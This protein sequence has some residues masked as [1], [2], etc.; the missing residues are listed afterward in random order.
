MGGRPS[1]EDIRKLPVEKAIQE[2]GAHPDTGLAPDEVKKRLTEYGY[3]EV[4]EKKKSPLMSFLK[5]F[6]GLTAWMLELTILISYVLGRLLDLA[7]IAALLLINAILGFFQEQQAERAVEALKKKLSVKAR[8]LRGG[9]WSVLPARELVPGDIVR[10]RSGDFVPAD[11][12]IID[13]DMEVDQSALTGESLPVEKKSGDLLYSGSLVRKGEA[14]G[15]IVSTGTRTYFGRTAQL[16]QAARPKLYVEEVITNLLKWLLAMVIALLA[17]AFIVSYFRGVSLLGLLPLALVLLVSSI[18][19]ALP[20]MFTVT[21]ALGSLELAKRGVL[22]TRLSA[23]Q[24]AAMM[25][26]LCADKT[27]TITM[28]KLSV[29]EMEGVGGYSADDV[30]FYGTLASQEAN[31]DP[32][33]LAFISEARRKGLNFNGYVQKKFTPFD[34]STRRTEAVIEKDGKEFTVIKGAVLTIAALCGVDPGEMAGLEKKIGSLAKKGYRAIVVAKGGEKQC[35]E[36]IGMAALYDP[37]RPDSAKLIEELR[38]L[39]I[40]TKMLTGDA[41]PIAREIA[42]EVKLGGKVTGMEDLKKMESIDP[43]KAEEIIEGSDG[44]AGVYPEDKY[45]IVKALQSKKHVVGMTGDGVNDAPALKQ[46]EVGIAVSSATD[47]AKGAASVV[48]TKEGLPEIVS[49]VRTGRS[50]HQR[51]VTWILNKIVKTFEIV[52]FVVLA[53][54]VTG[55]YVVGAFE[56]VL[57]LFL[58]DFVTISIATDN[59]RPSLKPETWDMRALVKVAILL[60]VFMVMESFG[61]LYIAMNYFRLT[62]AT[63]LRTLTFCMLIFGGMFTIFVV[64][65]RSYFWRSMPSKTLLLAIGGNM[66]VT[67]AIAIA[68]IPGLIPIPAAYVLIAWAWYFIFALLVNDFVKVRILPYLEAL[69]I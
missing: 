48:L 8:V 21:M 52:L 15:L 20:A 66:L 18:P 59:A 27:G 63:G 62:D 5:R 42:N 68:G 16:V 41:L 22:V 39:S 11:V 17:L 60:G 58:I 12:K 45:L 34:P 43:D 10:A 33:D 29:A 14:T 24:D 9:A 19:V 61:M 30:A 32:I 35:F 38:G 6:W 37:P 67:S 69:K 49:L 4:P 46:A 23:S 65:E 47:V 44:F 26:I 56:I 28:N 25:D 54:L 64:R 50:I 13:G 55:V 7:V 1:E 31:Q 57:L 53:Y 40:S 51:I 3:N 2:L 36:L